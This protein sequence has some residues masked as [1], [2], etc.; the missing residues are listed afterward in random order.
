MLELI[1]IKKTYKVGKFEQKAL[2]GVSL[3]FRE[4]EFVAI[5]GHSGSGKTTLLNIIGGLDHYDTGDLIINGKST[6]KYN[7]RDWD[8]YRNHS[9]GFVFQSYNLIPHQSVLSNVELALTLKGL[10][11]KERREKAREALIKVGLEDH[12]HKKP[13]QLSGGQMQRVAIA[14]ALV[15]DPDIL[16]ADEPTGA[17]DSETS[18]QIMDLLKAIASDKLVIMVT[19]NPDLANEYANRIIRIADGVI[20]SDSNPCAEHDPEQTGGRVK[21][22]SM[23]FFTGLSLSFNNLLTKKGRTLLTSGAGSIGII[24]IALITA[25]SSG[26]NAYIAD[27]ERDTL[28]SYPIMIEKQSVDM[29]EMIANL[30]TV[31]EQ[32]NTEHDLDA[33][34]SINITS[35][36]IDNLFGQ[37]S[38]N[39]L[40]AFKEY[41][42]NNKSDLDGVIN[43]IQ[44]SYSMPL[45]IY[46]A[47]T[48]E[49]YRVNPPTIIS[50]ILGRDLASSPFAQSSL[51][52]TDTWHEMIEN[53]DL[54]KAQYDI[55]SGEWADSFDEVMLFLTENNEVT[56]Y[57]LYSL[58][59]M[60]KDE[61]K[62]IIEH[63]QNNE[64]YDVPEVKTLSYDE[65][66]GK[67]YKL[68][69]NSDLYRY[70]A[71]NQIWEDISK[72]EEYL[73]K[74]IEKAI[75]IRI[76]GIA[77]PKD[78]AISQFS[79]GAIGYNAS[80]TRYMLNQISQ[81]DL[82]KAQLNNPD[83]DIFTNL[84][85]AK[86]GE[87]NGPTMDDI[88][89]YLMTRSPEEQARFAALSKTMTEEQIIQMFK[90]MLPETQSK[91]T[92]ED[93]IK[94]IGIIDLDNPSTISI[95]PVS[96]DA[97]DTIADFIRNYN[98]KETEAGHDENTIEYSDITALLMKSV[99][100]IINVISYVL[101]AFVA[102][103]LIVSSIM[104]GV[105]TNISV[106]ERTKEI[107]ILRA[108][109]A[110]KRDV[111]RVFNA[112]TL[113]IG[114]L[115]G[116]IGVGI[117]Y[118]LIIPINLL[119]KSLTDTTAH[120]FFDPRVAVLLVVIS[121]LLTLIS[122]FIPARSA[123]KKDPVIALRTE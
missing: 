77:R 65:I 9:I 109:G 8:T 20:T 40:E 54:Y 39:N 28:S 34:Y 26:V 89:A 99:T 64:E 81:S 68:L 63:I 37:V 38:T 13:N 56:D 32:N 36:M 115:A 69:L 96:F 83:V 112:E 18:I 66:V 95:Y 116:L 5:L 74:A 123:A 41:L 101:I 59:L 85:F 53:P 80:L 7:D 46:S 91:A 88:R 43:G 110:A 23:S 50:D 31:A 70:N 111:S 17:L 44:Y 117:T 98:N 120:A 16:L 2:N 62:D 122:G 14:R 84:P 61:L 67:E 113:I 87:S 11:R 106:L 90:N 97:K 82:A 71:V 21:R 102:I 49:V 108:M 12:I 75:P 100:T 73:K 118:L 10:K 119:I 51:I 114:L 52:N 29:T 58:G 47:V 48:D 35:N 42:E 93:N 78:G 72:D 86:E 1:D 27:V 57:L 15:N 24:G 94:K 25:I 45:T 79:A 33:V 19:H 3:T 30:A 4:N 107:G 92:Y 22:P 121:V 104:I 60:D 6:K 76:T 103:S 55:V 105:I